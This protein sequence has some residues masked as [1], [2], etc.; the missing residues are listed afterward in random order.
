MVVTASPSKATTEMVSTSPT[1]SARRPDSSGSGIV[2]GAGSIPPIIAASAGDGHPH[3]GSDAGQTQRVGG[4]EPAGVAER[5]RAAVLGGDPVALAGG[6]GHDPAG[7]RRLAQP[8]AGQ[9]TQV[10]GGAE[11]ED[12]TVGGEEP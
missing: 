10:G 2:A 4:A 5:R 1:V 8:V 3:D 6:G 7:C 9:R 11:G 12:P